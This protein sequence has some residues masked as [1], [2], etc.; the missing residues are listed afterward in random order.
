MRTATGEGRRLA[1]GRD[2][3]PIL[4]ADA[5]SSPARTRSS[6][7]SSAPL[8]TS[9]FSIMPRCPHSSTRIASAFG[10]NSMIRAVCSIGVIMSFSPPTTTVGT[11]LT[12]S[13]ARYSSSSQWRDSSQPP[14]PEESPRASRRRSRRSLAA[15]LI[16]RPS[17]GLPHIQD[18]FPRGVLAR[19]ARV[20]GSGPPSTAQRLGERCGPVCRGSVSDRSTPQRTC[21]TTRR[22]VPG[23]RRAQDG[24][25]QVA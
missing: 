5:H 18:R 15:R 4:I 23:C 7:R 14:P 25:G 6:N 10:S 11:V 12:I 1:G 19:R 16:R 22:P 24:T 2:Q 17:G 3:A 13:R 8:K 21:R 9:C 20:S